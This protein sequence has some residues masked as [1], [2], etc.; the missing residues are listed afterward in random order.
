[1]KNISIC[2]PTYSRA[3]K[4]KVLLEFLK[5]RAHLGFELVIGDNHSNDNTESVVNEYADCFNGFKYIKR[6]ENIGVSRNIDSILR[7]ASRKYLYVLSDD[8]FVFT[9]AL[10]VMA[11]ILDSNAEIVAVTGG[12]LSLRAPDL[13]LVMDYSDA[14]ASIIK[15]N[16]Q[17][18]VFKNMSVCDGHPLMRRDIFHRYCSYQD[19][20]FG[21]TP[22]FMTLLCHGDVV[23][24][25]KPIFQHITCSES[26]TGSMTEPWFID[27]G[28]SDIEIAKS[29]INKDIQGWSL[30]QTRNDLSR[31]FYF[32]AARMAWNKS[33]YLLLWFFLCRCKVI[34]A[35][36]EEL[37]VKCEH[38][39]M[40]DFVL[41]RIVQIVKDIDCSHLIYID[42]PHV[43][44]LVNCLKIIFPSFV[45]EVLN[46]H[47]N[48]FLSSMLIA[49]RHNEELACQFPTAYMLNIEDLINKYRLTAYPVAH[50]LDNERITLQFKDP[51]SL[52]LLAEETG[53]IQR[54]CALYSEA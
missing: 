27:M 51:N 9:E 22:M 28:M 35:V 1:M 15:K 12:Y 40:H 38:L 23:V 11:G 26:L 34:G 52:V 8:D 3:S 37:L 16:Q 18:Y 44:A 4:L 13:S 53:A 20:T 42:S 48:R 49:D 46:E 17:E 7:V 33:D 29:Q 54:L 47:T 31:L 41:A 50:F 2:I 5:N 19:R 6:K 24:I 45:F 10:Q 39:F 32:Q 36:S 25:N 21:L 14:I 43:I 30:E